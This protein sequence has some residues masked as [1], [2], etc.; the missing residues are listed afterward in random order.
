[1]DVQRAA[2]L[3]DLAGDFVKAEP[4]GSGHINDTYRVACSKRRYVLQ[5][6]NCSVFRHPQAVMQNIS[7]T[8]AHLQRSLPPD[9]LDGERRALRLIPTA[10][11]RDWLE[12]EDGEWWRAYPFIEGSMVLQQARRPDDVWKATRSFAEFQQMLADYV[13][14]PLAEVIPGFHH[15]PRRFEQLR[16][17]AAADSDGRVSDCRDLVVGFLEHSDYVGRLLAAHAADA[18]PLRITHN[19]AK[20]N[21]ILFD[22]ESEDALCVIDLDTLMPGLGLYDV[23]DLIRTGC[24]AA[25]EDCEDISQMVADQEMVSAIVDSWLSGMGAQLTPAERELIIVAGATITIEVGSR[26]LADYLG[27]DTYFKVHRPRHNLIRARAQLAL[28]N[29]LIARHDEL[30]AAAGL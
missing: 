27:G 3:F 6:L 19:D 26:F 24:C 23:G 18:V 20:L 30:A 10:E 16:A 29:D 15:T 22:R 7:L 21:N 1:M 11:G 28:A 17:A 2:E 25:A 12:A 4:W 5:R 13:G 9:L 14:P 8:C